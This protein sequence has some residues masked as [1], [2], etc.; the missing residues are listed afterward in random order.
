MQCQSIRTL[1]LSLSLLSLAG[2]S[3]CAPPAPPVTYLDDPDQGPS[4]FDAINERLGIDDPDSV[5]LVY[6]ADAN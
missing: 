3:A 1:A 2:A 5:D 6:H 4:P